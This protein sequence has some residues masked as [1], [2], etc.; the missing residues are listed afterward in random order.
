[1]YSASPATATA[2]L[3][4][5]E[6]ELQRLPGRVAAAHAASWQDSSEHESRLGRARLGLRGVCNKKSPV[7]FLG[8][9]VPCCAVPAGGT[10]LSPSPLPCGRTRHL[11]LRRRP[12]GGWRQPEA[13]PGQGHED[14]PGRAAA[15]DPHVPG[16]HGRHAAAEVP[17]LPGWHRP[18]CP[19]LLQPGLALGHKGWGTG[20]LPGRAVATGRASLSAGPWGARRAAGRA[21]GTARPSA[22][23]AWQQPQRG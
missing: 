14:R 1:M 18:P 4:C 21:Q 13:L 17:A 9:H 3:L 15:G 8:G 6:Q 10:G 7:G 5:A 22:A 11:Q 20:V 16:G 23:A 19:A 2:L 12:R